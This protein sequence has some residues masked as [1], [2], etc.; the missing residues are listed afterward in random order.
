MATRFDYVVSLDVH[1]LKDYMTY[2]DSKLAPVAEVTIRCKNSPRSNRDDEAT[3]PSGERLYENLWYHEA[4]PLGC[5]RYWRMKILEGGVGA[6]RVLPGKE[7]S[8]FPDACAD[9][10]ARMLLDTAIPGGITQIVIVPQDAYESIASSLGRFN[11]LPVTA[12]LETA[13]GGRINFML[14]SDPFDNRYNK[15]FVLK[16]GTNNAG[17]Y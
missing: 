11:I 15:H 3:P 5:K 12:K 2:K 16:E 8:D 4:M 9:A 17:E 1:K 10:I 6:V 7:A 14:T 13:I